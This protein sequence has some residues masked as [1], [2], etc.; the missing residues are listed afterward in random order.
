MTESSPHDSGH[1]SPAQSLQ[2][3]D[4][5]AVAPELPDEGRL[6]GVDFGTVRI[7]L[8][9]CDE[10]QRWVTPLDTYNRRNLR[11]DAAH[12]ASLV[13]QDGVA[14]I[15]VGLPI[16]CDG[17]ESQKSKEVRQF[18]VWLSEATGVPVTQ[19][20]ERFTTAEA[21]RLLDERP[22]SAK[23]KK[24]KLDGVAAHLILSHFLDS[25]RHCDHEPSGL[26][27]QPT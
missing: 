24:K 1:N 16:H 6:L 10:S 23:K 22:M 15:V 20:D 3:E 18:C 5:P 21:R 13:K 9:L 7:G 27:D 17:K 26:D 14:G 12:F 25:A 19:F 2:S 4:E 8:A 11:S